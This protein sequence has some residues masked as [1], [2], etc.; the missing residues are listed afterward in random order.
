MK[1]K[2]RNSEKTKEA[3]LKAAVNEIIEHGYHGARM[4]AIADKAKIN[5]AMIHYY[6]K[7]KKTMYKEAL[8]DVMN[9]LIVKLGDIPDEPVAVDKK[10]EQILDVYIEVFDNYHDYTRL[11]IYE[12]MRGGKLIIPII[13]KKIKDI[14]F[15]PITG[16]IHK[17]FKARTRPR[18]TSCSSAA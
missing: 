7:N 10:I 18:R 12:A 11:M 4:Q 3:I 16:K 6:Y 8:N 15:N 5:K 1:T 2:Q 13:V 17:Y 14:P 9:I